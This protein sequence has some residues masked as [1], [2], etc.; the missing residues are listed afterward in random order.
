MNRPILA[1]VWSLLAALAIIVIVSALWLAWYRTFPRGT[2]FD[3]LSGVAVPFGLLF[4]TAVWLVVRAVAHGRMNWH[5]VTVSVAAL[6]LAYGQVAI[7]CGPFACFTPGST[8]MMGWFLVI[9]AVVAATVHHFV[10]NLASP[11][12]V[13][14]AHSNTRRRDH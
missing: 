2:G 11:D 14:V 4:L 5:I 6:A 12:K 3:D 13:M 10:L 7:Y 8:R 1:H 9:G